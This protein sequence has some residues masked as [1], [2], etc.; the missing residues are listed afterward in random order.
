MNE[1]AKRS[2]FGALYVALVVVCLKVYPPLAPSLFVLFSLLCVVEVIQLSALKRLNM[3]WFVGLWLLTWAAFY[4]PY[5]PYI[6]AASL[7]LLYFLS[8]ALEKATW[9]ALYV[10]QPFVLSIFVVQSGLLPNYDIVLMVFILIWLNDSGA[11]IFGRAFGKTLLAPQVSPKKTW[12]GFIG[13]IATAAGLQLLIF[14]LIF[15]GHNLLYGIFAAILIGSAA[16]VGDLIQSKMKRKAGVKDSGNILP[17]HG[18]AFDRLDSFI[19]A[20]PIALIFYLVIYL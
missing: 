13:G 18:G 15:E 10:L 16:T 12:E 1:L 8:A 17:G 7:A 19:F 20:L 4:V 5:Y 9:R 14:P 11:Y 2:V 3:G 6:I